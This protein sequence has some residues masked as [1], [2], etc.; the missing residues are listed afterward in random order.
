MLFGL[1]GEI[2]EVDRTKRTVIGYPST[3][4][5]IDDGMDVVERGAFARTINAW[6]PDGKQRIKALYQHE[7]AWMIGK[8]ES[9]AEDE[10]G[11]LARTRFVDTPMAND[12]L[13]L[14]QEGVITEQSIGF[15]VVLRDTDD[16]GIR[17]LRELKLYE[18]SFVTW[19][20]N[21]ITPILG[22]KGTRNPEDIKARMERMESALK[23]ERFDSDDIP[24]L[25]EIAIAQWKDALPSSNDD[26]VEALLR[27]VSALKEGRVISARNLSLLE[28]AIDA[29]TALLTATDPAKSTRSNQDPP[30]EPKSDPF[31]DLVGELKSTKESELAR[32]LA[33][34]AASLK[35]GR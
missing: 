26:E 23:S 3:F 15:D 6:G 22:V 2:K 16:S 28:A 31:S 29:L 17:H 20:M 5:V 24:H 1:K 12:V 18:T 19:G 13:T 30:K 4:G 9:L 25:M 34:F 10:R 35:E 7:P 8:H 33:S 32:E 27:K 14:I 11:L 21:E